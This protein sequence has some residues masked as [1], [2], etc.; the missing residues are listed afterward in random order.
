MDGLIFIPGEP[1]PAL[2]A[3]APLAPGRA[4]A[5]DP[6]PVAWNAFTSSD[7]RTFAGTWESGPGKWR[8]QYTEDE[9]C[10][11]LS[12]ESELAH[13]DGRRWRLRAGDRFL[14]PSGFAGTWEVLATTR[15]IYVV[16]ER[17]S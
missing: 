9:Y 7:G 10:E 11:I 6:R 14:I 17:G 1:D 2:R 15:K 13:E 12:G 16:V 5:G 3:E 4:L 8:V